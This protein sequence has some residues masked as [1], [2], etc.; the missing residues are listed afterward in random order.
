MLAVL[1]TTPEIALTEPESKQLAIGIKNVARHY[2]LTTTQK[3]ADWVLL[4]IALGT[5]YGPRFVMIAGKAKHK[6]H[7]IQNDPASAQ[8]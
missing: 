6:G 4:S 3:T 8:I 2:D 7:V 1:T 5:I